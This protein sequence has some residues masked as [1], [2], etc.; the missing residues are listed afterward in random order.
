[1]LFPFDGCPEFGP[2]SD[3]ERAVHS[4]RAFGEKVVADDLLHPEL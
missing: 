4:A 1:M 2:Y 3:P